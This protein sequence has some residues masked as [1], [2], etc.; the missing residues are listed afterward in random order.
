MDKEVHGFQRKNVLVTG[1][2]GYIGSHTIVCLLEAGYD[3]T[4]VDNLCNSS[5]RSLQRVQQIAHCQDAADRIRFFKVDLRDKDALEVVFQVSPKFASC[6]HFAG[7]KA[8]GE[9][10]HLPLLYYE[11]NIGGTLV[12]LDLLDKYHCHHLVFSSSATV[13]GNEHSPITESAQVG[14]GI[15]NAYGRTKFMIEEIL[16]DFRVS[17]E[18]NRNTDNTRDDWS[19][20][21]LRYFNPI[22]AHPSGKIGDNPNGIP[23]NL[24]PYLTQVAVGKREKLTIFGQDYPTPDGTGVRDYIHVVDLAEAHVTSL[25]YMDNNP[26]GYYLF[27]IGTGVGVSVFEIIRSFEKAC[28]HK[29]H[30]EIGPRRV[31][32]VAVNYADT[33]KAREVLGWTASKSL[34]QACEDSWRWQSDNPN[35]YDEPIVS[36]SDVE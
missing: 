11:N 14:R 31:G 19:I 36:P 30:F 35:G 3:V 6:I 28:G 1:G 20:T 29:I 5:E 18:V 34:D 25:G 7:L 24:M 9:S 2:T 23:N 4:V 17:K 13:Y 15:T 12:L 10:L 32:D 8:V 16:H 21:I 27:N 22:G 26:P 33:T